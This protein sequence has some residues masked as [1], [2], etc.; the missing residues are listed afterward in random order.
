MGPLKLVP[1][2]AV[3]QPRH[4]PIEAAQIGGFRLAEVKAVRGMVLRGMVSQ[5][6]CLVAMLC[7]CRHAWQRNN[8]VE[9]CTKPRALWQ[10]V[11]KSHL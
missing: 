5:G 3:A 9:A 8:V 11:V 2:F 7:R 4:V 6:W 10:C 1:A